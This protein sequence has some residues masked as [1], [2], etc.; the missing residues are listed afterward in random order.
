[1]PSGTY[2]IAVG[3]HTTL[4]MLCFVL[5]FFIVQTFNSEYL[6]EK[7]LN[8]QNETKAEI[9]VF[10][11]FSLIITFVTIWLVKQLVKA[12]DP[13]CNIQVENIFQFYYLTILFS[14]NLRLLV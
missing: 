1:M 2:E 13:G 12:L 10:N 8:N 4:C 6:K 3:A 5:C 7:I 11:Y 9:T 14:C